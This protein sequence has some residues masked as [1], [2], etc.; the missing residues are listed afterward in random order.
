MYLDGGKSSFI[1]LGRSLGAYE[2]DTH[3]EPQAS[4]CT[5]ARY[6]PSESFEV[7]GIH[8]WQ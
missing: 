5:D 7:G 6:L 1:H 4:L 2:R 3:P 8:A